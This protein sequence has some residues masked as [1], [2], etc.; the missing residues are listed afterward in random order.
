MA[1]EFDVYLRNHLT[2]CDLFIY[3][4]PYRDGISVT[5]CLVLDAALNDYI[6]QKI[7]A[8]HVGLDLTAQIGQI[9]KLCSEKLSAG[10]GLN[11]AADF[12]MDAQLYLGHSPLV[13]NI[14]AIEMVGRVLN[15]AESGMVLSAKPLITQL[16]SSAGGGNFPLLVSSS[17][18]GIDKKS[19]LRISPWTVVN[20]S[21][22]QINQLDYLVTGVPSAIV[23]SIKNLCYQVP[24]E[25]SSNVEITVIVLGAEVRHSL[26][27]WYNG[28]NIDGKVVDT[29]A[30][31][32]IAV[33]TI[34][35]MT[36]EATGI[37]KKV[38]YPESRSIAIEAASLN[39]DMK[40]Y[41]LLLE[42]DD[43]TL[44]DIDNMTLE[45]LDFVWLT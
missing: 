21:I 16:S 28:A 33:P 42:V 13:I 6:L 31:K 7:A 25:A 20:A 2:E 44:G 45:E 37:P 1:K 4:I 5:N 10:V 34:T 30:Y 40:R 9:I 41:R 26:G 15:V 11:A 12:E 27:S 35:G 8:T 43:S 17:I 32:F 14:P 29:L 19:V 22:A 36:Q 39:V 38:I 23:S 18:V 3:S 24:F